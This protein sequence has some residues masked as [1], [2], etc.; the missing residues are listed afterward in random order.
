MTHESTLKNIQTISTHIL[1]E[2]KDSLKS[3]KIAVL[4]DQLNA[5]DDILANNK[6]MIG[7]Y[8]F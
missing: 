1:S 2:K 3:D 5:M 6:I 8:D 7:K 4:T